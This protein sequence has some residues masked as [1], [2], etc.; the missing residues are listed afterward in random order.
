[1]RSSMVQIVV[2]N[3]AGME[4]GCLHFDR[5]EMTGAVEWR[6]GWL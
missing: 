2:I 4:A 1:M 5:K 6:F 3:V